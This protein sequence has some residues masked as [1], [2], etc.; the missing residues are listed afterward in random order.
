MRSSTIIT[1]GLFLI[2]AIAESVVDGKSA[3]HL[4]AEKTIGP[5]NVVSFS[6]TKAYQ[7]SDRTAIV[8]ECAGAQG[9][10]EGL[11]ILS[12][13]EIEELVILRSR[14]G[15]NRSALKDPEF[16]RSF[17]QN[18]DEL[19]LEVDAVSGA[20]VSSQIVIDEVNRCV[21]EWKKLNE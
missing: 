18:I 13:N 1:I 11:L 7:G 6:E 12:E 9:R 21:K 17:Q 3:H 19:P 14:E 15:L 2:A 8:I 4:L 10:I 20:T 5:C 16:Q